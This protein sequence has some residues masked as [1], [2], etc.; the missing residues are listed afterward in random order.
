MKLKILMRS[1]VD[2]GYSASVP[3]MP[4]C[5]SQGDTL[6]EAIANIH[7]AAE[8]WAEVQVDRVTLSAENE[9]TAV[10]ARW[11]PCTRPTDH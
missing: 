10:K 3:A 6:N 9:S 11:S 2:G 5:H 4:G 8:L 1:E 7:E